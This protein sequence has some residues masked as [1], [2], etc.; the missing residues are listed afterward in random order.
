MVVWENPFQGKTKAWIKTWDTVRWLLIYHRWEAIVFFFS[1][2]RFG[3]QEKK[4]TGLD[5]GLKEKDEPDLPGFLFEQV[6]GKS[7][8]SMNRNSREGQVSLIHYFV[9]N[10]S[11]SILLKL[12]L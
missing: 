7:D 4:N 5:N 10:Q 2:E 3:L 11:S 8:N 9:S 1:E 6:H 12:S